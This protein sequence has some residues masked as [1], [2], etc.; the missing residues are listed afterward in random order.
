MSGSISV[1]YRLSSVISVIQ[2]ILLLDLAVSKTHTPSSPTQHMP[3]PSIAL[4]LAEAARKLTEAG[5]DTPHLDAEL[6]LAHSLGVQRT[7]LMAHP[8]HLLSSAQEEH[9]R[10]LLARRQQREPLA[11]ITGRRWFYDFELLVT[12]DVLI[13]RPET[14]GL[15]ER[16][17]RW[18]RQ[19]PQATVADIGT[20]SGAIALAIARHAAPGVHIFATDVSKPALNVARENAR[21]LG[22]STRLHFR[23][24]DL[25]AALPHP[26]DL[27]LANLPYVARDDAANLMPEV[28]VFE[29]QQ[30]LFSGPTGLNHIRRLLAQA[31]DFLQ[32]QGAILLEIGWNQGDEVVGMARQH[33]PTAHI[34]LHKDLSGNDRILEVNTAL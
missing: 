18:L 28:G 33:F 11:Y 12:P 19:H 8:E 13:P 6:L 17:L 31:A 4:I 21:R 10:E 25:L 26:V 27:I 2:G 16:A 30:A 23:H 9:F 24:G 29:P 20:G 7:W 1:V 15:V 34:H 14:E 3:P 32:P 22:L 5:V